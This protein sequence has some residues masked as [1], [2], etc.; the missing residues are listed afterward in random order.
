MANRRSDCKL[1]CEEFLD[2]AARQPRSR[3]LVMF[4]SGAEEAFG[5]VVLH[6]AG[7]HATAAADAFIDIDRHGPAVVGDLVVGRSLGGTRQNVLSGDGGRAGEGDEKTAV[8]IH[9]LSTFA[10]GSVP[11]WGLC[12]VWQVLQGKPCECSAATTVGSHF[13]LALLAP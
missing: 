12:G 4:D 9:F 7:A 10:A 8:H 1:G 5:N 3:H 6:R 11:M 2:A 13:G